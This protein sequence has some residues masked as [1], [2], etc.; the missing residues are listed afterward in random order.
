M[1][2]T[3][4][5]VMNFLHNDN[6]FFLYSQGCMAG[7]FDLADC[8]TEYMTIKS[9]YAAFAAVT[10]ARYGWGNSTTDG[11]SQRF[12]REFWDAV[13]NPAEAKIEISKANSDSKE[14]NIYRINESCMR[15]CTYELNV[16][17]DPSIAIRKGSVGITADVTTGNPPLDVN[18]MGISGL[19]VQSWTWDFGDGGSAYTQSPI[20]TYLERGLYDVS[21]QIN[22]G[23]NTFSSTRSSYIAVIADTVIAPTAVG[24]P[25]EQ[26]VLTLTATNTAPM[27]S[28]LI[29]VEYP[30]NVNMT[31]DSLSLVGCRTESCGTIETLHY[32]PFNKR[33]AFK[34]NYAS[35]ELSPG[36]GE[37]LKIY[38]TINGSA[39][40]EQMATIELDGYNTYTPLFSGSITS[41]I[42]ETISGN[43]MV[44]VPSC[45]IGIRGNINDDAEQTIDI[46]DLVYFVEYSFGNPQGPEPPCFEEADV[47][48]SEAIDIGDLVYMVDF[49]FGSPA[50]PAPLICQ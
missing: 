10:N 15:W 29:P 48:A 17:G 7:Q 43:V 39:V 47:D 38:F 32:D 36:Q 11:P 25:G 49:M 23:E 26:V 45:C 20:H 21:L 46:S 13:F 33:A 35:N 44:Y 28:M 42:A 16:F 19:S 27:S 30:G 22:T 2:M 9:D 37:I 14:D 1:K 3:S 31:L 50:G 24:M 4:T 40:N 34:I 41:Y 8:V 5:D 6:H 12:D 18:F